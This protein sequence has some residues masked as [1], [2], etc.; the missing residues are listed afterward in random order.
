VKIAIVNNCV[1]FVAGGAEHLAES[2]RDKLIESGHEAMLTRIPFRWHPAESVVDHILAC[3]LLCLRGVDRVIGLKFPAYFLPHDNK[4]L[5][6]LHQFRQAYDLWGTPY[7]DIPDTPEGLRIRQVVIESDNQY[8]REAKKIYTNSHVTGDRLKKFNGIES[9][10]LFPPLN[11][12]G[13]FFCSGYGDY[14]FYPSRVTGGKRQ[15]LVVKS[16][17]Y[18]KSPVRL[19]IGGQPELPADCEAV[20]RA[21]REAGVES[22]V[23]FIPRFLTEQEKADLFAG[24]LGCAYTPY[25]EDSYGYVTLE[26]YHSRKPVITCTD[27]GGVSILVKNGETGFV[28]GPSPE[29]IGQAMDCLYEDRG[30]AKRMGEAGYDLMNTLGINWAT[31]VERLTA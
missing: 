29:A 16:M 31:V 6:L 17:K 19:V 2:L 27:S 7:Q 8:L 12:S 13:H 25:D 24:A 28:V 22:R 14:I 15:T 21:I 11:R 9:E 10:I 26:S 20:E 4:V 30:N 18:C 23:Q 5:W 3:R 1:P